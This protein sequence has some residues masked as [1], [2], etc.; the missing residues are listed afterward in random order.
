MLL[1]SPL[2]HIVTFTSLFS[3]LRPGFH[4]LQRG[5]LA[6]AH[7]VFG[8]DILDRDAKV[9]FVLVLKHFSLN[10]KLNLQFKCSD[11]TEPGL[12]LSSLKWCGCGEGGGGGG[13]GDK[14][15]VAAVQGG[16]GGE[17]VVVV[18][19]NEKVAP[20]GG[21]P[22]TQYPVDYVY[23][24]PMTDMDLQHNATSPGCTYKWYTGTPVYDFGYGLRYT[25]FSHKWAKAP[26]STYSIQTLVQSGNLYSYLHLAPFDTFT[27]NFTNAGN[28][29]SA[30]ASLLFVNRTYGPSPYLNK[31][32]ITSACLHDI[33]S[34]DTASVALAVTLG[35]IARADTYG[36][37][38]QITD[39]TT[40]NTV[41]DDVMGPSPHGQLHC[42][43]EDFERPK[44]EYTKS[45]LRNQSAN[46]KNGERFVLIIEEPYPHNEYIQ[47]LLGLG[48]G[49]RDAYYQ[50]LL[51]VLAGWERY[52]VSDL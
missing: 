30:F 29:T 39:V 51:I 12:G 47:A 16:G 11:Q 17:V 8:L 33:A 37:A 22:V 34:G 26:S 20:T 23:E 36:S 40:K 41:A 4:V 31:S 3:I 50:S 38:T 18:V 49:W 19:L 21:L 10:P 43:V 25:T 5:I 45:G 52:P 35:S 28:V 24:I 15:A 7:S 42:R 2:V 46:K 32:I 48:A 6:I 9:Q 1:P 44:G 13:G 27:I 14:E